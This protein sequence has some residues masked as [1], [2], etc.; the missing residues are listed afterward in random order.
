MTTRAVVFAVLVA[1]VVALLFG[2]ALGVRAVTPP[3]TKPTLKGVMIVKI[4]QWLESLDSHSF[5]PVEQIVQ[6]FEAKTGR[7][8]PTFPTFTL[9]E[10]LTAMKARGLGGQINPALKGSE[11][12][13][14]GWD[15]AETLAETFTESREH[16]GYMG[17]GR[18]YDTA[19]Q[20]LRREDI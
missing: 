3:P 1:F 4:W 7:R 9:A 8:A 5:Y 6:D 10:T 13:V 20:A 15:V 17:R 12:V 18:R 16:R 11:R 2:I 19:L 14:N